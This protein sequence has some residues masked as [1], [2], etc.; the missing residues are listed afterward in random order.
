MIS[1]SLR[2]DS[3]IHRNRGL[4]SHNV[5][6]VEIRAEIDFFGFVRNA[7]KFFGTHA[8][9]VLPPA[10]FRSM[11]FNRCASGDSG[12]WFLLLFV[13]LNQ[14]LQLNVMSTT[15]FKSKRPIYIF[16]YSL[17][18]PPEG[19]ELNGRYKCANY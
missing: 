11:I 1:A 17:H 14:S 15:V 3:L 5:Q 9:S 8:H 12:S 18:S 4:M 19:R 6:F 7:L 2:A 13:L 10:F 16:F